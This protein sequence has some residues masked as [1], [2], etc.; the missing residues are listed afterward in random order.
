MVELP[1]EL[2]FVARFWPSGQSGR[3][4]DAAKAAAVISLGRCSLHLRSDCV[5]GLTWRGG[6]VRT[7]ERPHRLHRFYFRGRL[8][9][10]DYISKGMGL[11]VLSALCMHAKEFG[12]SC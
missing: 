11:L 4:H 8:A 3:V 12:A 2:L 5:Q 10:R 7:P 9:A 6:L 1:C